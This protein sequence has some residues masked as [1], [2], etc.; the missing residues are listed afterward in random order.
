MQR[1]VFQ[2]VVRHQDPEEGGDHQEGR[3]GAHDDRE[4]GPS[5]YKASFPNS[6]FPHVLTTI[7]LTRHFAGIEVL[8]H[9]PGQTV[10]CYGICKWRGTLLPSL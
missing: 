2:P 8:V 5:V 3:G 1:E 6:K 7:A 4:Q 9:D 10:L